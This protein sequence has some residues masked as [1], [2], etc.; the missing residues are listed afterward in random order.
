M[1][2][3]VLIA[4]FFAAAACVPTD[5]GDDKSPAAQPLPPYPPGYTAVSKVP[6]VVLAGLPA[7]VAP[8]QVLITDE[9]CYYYHRGATTYPV[10]GDNPL[11]RYCTPRE[12]FGQIINIP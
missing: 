5:E 11:Q 6:E 7:D 10:T 4:C 9:G 2:P 8:E 3:A 12:P 1:K